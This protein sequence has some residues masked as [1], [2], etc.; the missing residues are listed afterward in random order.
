MAKFRSFLVEPSGT[1]GDVTFVRTR[2]GN[3]MRAARGSKT[4]AV[5]NS[6]LQNQVSRNDIVNGA[7]KLVHN[8]IKAY[9]PHFKQ[10]NL[11]QSIL[12][13]IRRAEQDNLLSLLRAVEGLEVHERHPLEQM[14]PDAAINV[15]LS[16]DILTIGLQTPFKP[17]FNLPDEPNC[18]YYEMHILFINASK[19]AIKTETIDSGWVT[20]K[21][22]QRAFEMAFEVPSSARYYV[23]LL[24]LQ[25]GF[26]KVAVEDFRSMGVRVMKVGERN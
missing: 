5:C 12:K 21:A 7:A 22:H 11:W 23:V 8:F 19:V 3:Y 2:N 16:D 26:G 10:S 24:K 9:T 15:Q 4:K 14:I 13:R 6:A 18:Y 1:I 25:G 17:W 20:P